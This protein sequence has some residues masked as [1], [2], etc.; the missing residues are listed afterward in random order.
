MII[1]NRRTIPL[2][3]IKSLADNIT[4]VA[5]GS[6]SANPILVYISTNVGTTLINI[7][8]VTN[9]ATVSNTAG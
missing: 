5:D 6:F 9:K 7:N 2:A 8:V 4:L 1:E 3:L